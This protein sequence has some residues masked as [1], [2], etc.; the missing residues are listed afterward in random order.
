MDS[1]Q[2]RE[3]DR[4]G[5]GQ[6]YIDSGFHPAIFRPTQKTIDEMAVAVAGQSNSFLNSLLQHYHGE[7]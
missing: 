1:T 7:A 4:K 2:H 3:P 5:E 6:D